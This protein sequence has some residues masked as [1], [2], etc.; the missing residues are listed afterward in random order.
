MRGLNG[1]AGPATWMAMRARR[2]SAAERRGYLFPY[3]SWANRV[4]VHRFVRDIPMEAAHPSRPVLEGIAS[5]LPSLGPAP[6]LILWG[7][8]D[9]CFD[10]W[11]FA[12]WR[13]IYP[14]AEVER[15]AAAGHYVLED[16]GAEARGRIGEFLLGKCPA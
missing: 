16:A 2:L 13:E 8:R 1:F 5:A 9:F 3:D 14:G 7:G 11:F 4:G 12:R 6:K 10:D 15:L